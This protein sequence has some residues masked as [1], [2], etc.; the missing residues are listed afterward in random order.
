MSNLRRFF[1]PQTN[2][3]TE[4][5]IDGEE[6]YHAIKIL[7]LGVG[8][9][10]IVCNGNGT[11]YRAVINKISK[12]N[13]L[14]TIVG[15]SL[16]ETEPKTKVILCCGYLKGDKTELVCKQAVELGVTEI[17]VFNSQ[18][19]SAYMSDNKLARL[20]KVTIEAC[21][22]CGRN[23][24]VNVKYYDSLQK[25]LQDYSTC[26]NKLFA[27]EFDNGQREKL[28]LLQGDAVVVVGS[29]GGFSEKESQT[30]IDLGYKS[31]SLGK[32]ILR[33][34]TACTTSLSLVMFLAGELQ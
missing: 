31:I 5:I 10:I 6:F 27:C 7:R 2:L 8:D 13:M 26:Q 12:E 20:N 22:Q 11:D 32:R 14:C 19:S 24:I 4:V 15:Q 34:E 17:A 25:A 29:E 30:A 33:A 9:E 23:A 1:T 28:S 3:Q 16:S 21:K 18:F